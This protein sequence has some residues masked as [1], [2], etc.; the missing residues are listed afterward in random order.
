MIICIKLC[1]RGTHWT[2]IKIQFTTDRVETNP[3]SQRRCQ[4]GFQGKTSPLGVASSES[5]GENVLG[6]GFLVASRR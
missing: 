4:S 3:V 6:F 2:R 5:P 1:F